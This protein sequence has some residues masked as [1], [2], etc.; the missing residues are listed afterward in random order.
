MSY[1]NT[2]IPMRGPGRDPVDLVK[3]MP[4][5]DLFVEIGVYAGEFSRFILESGKV[6][7]LVAV[8]PWSNGYDAADGASESDLRGAERAF[9]ER[10]APWL[11]DGRCRKIKLPSLEAARVFHEGQ[12]CMVYIDACHTYE[13]VKA[14]IRTWRPKIK[15]GGILAGHDYAGWAGVRQ[16]VDEVAG[17]PQ[18]TFIDASWATVMPK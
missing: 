12:I 18:I 11:A 10:L 9:D 6:K 8:D 13:A 5:C 3:W 4:Q 7:T 16:A 2:I 14:D 15:P 1:A 17:V